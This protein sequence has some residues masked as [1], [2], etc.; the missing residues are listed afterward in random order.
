MRREELEMKKML[1][2]GFCVVVVVSAL[3]ALASTDVDS[4]IK[5]LDELGAKM[6][7]AMVEGDFETMLAY[8]AD[9]TVLLPNWG[10]KIVGKDAIREKMESDREAGLDF[11]SFT[12]QTEAAW[13][14]GGKVYAVGTYALSVTVPGVERP[15]ADKGK[16]MSVWRRAEDGTLTIIYDM[17]NTDV[18]MGE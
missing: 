7:R 3:P 17:W 5:E 16:F 2:F 15:V 8:Y 12:G 9:D 11:E 10:K 14:C 13:E 18:P 4:L 6:E 1:N